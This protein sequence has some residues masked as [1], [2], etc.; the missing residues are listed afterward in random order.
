MTWAQQGSTLC[1]V[2]NLPSCSNIS[3]ISRRS[4]QQSLPSTASSASLNPANVSYDK[5]LGVEAI[6]QSFN[7]SLFNLST[8]NERIGGV[9]INSNLENSFFANR[10][11]EV[12]SERIEREINYKQFTTD[13]YSFALGSKIIKRKNFNL[14]LGILLKYNTD[15]HRLNP[16][17][18][19]SSKI[20]PI[21]LGASIYQDD[22]LLKSISYQER[23]TVLTYS[24]GTRI[25]NFAFDI[26]TIKSK[27]LYYQNEEN[28][29]YLYSF[30]YAFKNVLLNYAVRNEKGPFPDFFNNE[31]KTKE[32]KVDSFA[33]IQ[34][35][36]GKHLTLG[37]SHNYFL[38]NELTLST[39]IFF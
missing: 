5:G 11:P 27:Y 3:R 20:G 1:D 22:Y 26:G 10:T 15:I 32:T 21:T 13:K 4:S 39:A 9:L 23:F 12:E 34:W 38:L 25:K 6:H 19:L 35:S 2:L 30:A 28:T 7:S 24:A 18:G 33:S 31:L 17:A 8:G 29:I 16:G 37:I 14:D 36:I